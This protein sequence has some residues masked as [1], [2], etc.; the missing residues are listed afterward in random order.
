MNKSTTEK[1]K[2]YVALANELPLSPGECQLFYLLG[3]EPDVR[4]VL[5]E[6][7]S[8]K[9]RYIENLTFRP[10]VGLPLG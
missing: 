4:K 1:L 2:L 5:D 3:Q 8:A 9:K 6:A 10:I 7:V